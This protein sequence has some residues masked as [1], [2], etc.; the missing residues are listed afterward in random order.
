MEVKTPEEVLETYLWAH[1]PLTKAMGIKSELATSQKIVLSAPLSLNINHKLTAFGGSLHS[2]ATLACWSLLHV[3]LK[4]LGFEKAQI[5]IAKS[6]VSY[7]IP[8]NSDF[9]A[10][11]CFSDSLEW[12]KFFKTL[13]RKGKARIELKAKILQDMKL[14]IDYTGTFV[15]ILTS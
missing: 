11:C 1:I 15:A 5:V 3:N 9:K 12:D 6:E 10:E 4:K 8:V 7:L 14:C 13:T 2:I